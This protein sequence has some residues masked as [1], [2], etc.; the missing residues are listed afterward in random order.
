VIAHKRAKE[1]LAVINDPHTVLPDETFDTEKTITLGGTA[2][3]LRYLGLNLSDSNVV[4]RLPK[5]KLIFLVDTIP[6]GTMPGLGMIDIY[7][8]ETEDFIE[9]VIA[10][11]WD[12]MIPGHPRA[13]RRAARSQG[14]RPQHFGADAGSLGGDQETRARGQMLAAGGKGIQ[15]VEVCGMA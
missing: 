6:V 7:P 9:K 11:D 15:D 3:E 10:L 4:M 1:R 13:A 12:R 2:L 14:R 8:L 5:E